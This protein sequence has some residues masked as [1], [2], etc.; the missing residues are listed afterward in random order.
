LLHDGFLVSLNVTTS[1]VVVSTPGDA[2]GDHIVDDA[3]LA[4]FTNQFGVVGAG[5]SADFDDDGDVDLDDFGIMRGNWGFGTGGSPLAPEFTPTPEPATMSLL[6]L[7]GLA[8]LR[9][10]RRRS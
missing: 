1:G 7:G 6:T 5:Q 9:R 3:D 4:I 10:R 2:T 8:I